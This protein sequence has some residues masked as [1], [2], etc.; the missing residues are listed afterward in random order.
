MSD[1]TAL[2]DGFN[3]VGIGEIEA[4]VSRQL[5]LEQDP[6]GPPIQKSRMS[7]LVVY[8][9]QPDQVAP[10]LEEVGEI[11]EVHPARVLF[12]ATDPAGDSDDLEAGVRVR[13]RYVRGGRQEVGSELVVLRAGGRSDDRLPY[14]VRGLLIGDLPTNLWWASRLPPSLAGPLL[15]DLT[16]QTQQLIYDSLGWIDPHR[17]MSATAGWLSRFERDGKSGPWRVASDVNWRRLKTWRRLIAQ[18]LDPATAPGAIESIDDVLIEHGPHAVTKAWEL[19][20][21]L[22]ARLGWRVRARKVEPGVEI[23]WDVQAPWGPV[24]LTIRRLA[25]GPPVIQRMRIACKLCGESGALDLLNDQRTRLTAVPEGKDVALR[26][27]SIKP[28]PHSELVGRQLVDRE[29]DPVFAE[30]MGIAQVLAQ[31]VG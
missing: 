8:C 10:L 23:G 13:T 12:L 24:R 27:V 19:A 11:I 7:N 4:E 20:S 17:G 14:L 26:T 2:P 15:Y 1:P 31:G 25:Q 5:C 28:L 29:R 3:R 21:W 6:D 22:S 18:S 30:A 16:E 9:D